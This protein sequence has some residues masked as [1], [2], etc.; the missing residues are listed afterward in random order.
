MCMAYPILNGSLQLHE[1]QQRRDLFRFG[2]CHRLHVCKF[3]LR[4]CGETTKLL[5]C[6]GLVVTQSNV[7]D[8]MFGV[9]AENKSRAVL[10]DAVGAL[11]CLGAI[12]HTLHGTELS[13]EFWESTACVR[14]STAEV[15]LVRPSTSISLSSQGEEQPIYA[16]KF[17]KECRSDSDLSCEVKNLMRAQ[18]HPNIC[19]FEGIFHSR[20]C[21]GVHQCLMLMEAYPRGDLMSIM[22]QHG[23][24][25]EIEALEATDGVLQA[26]SHIH[27]LG[28]IHRDV[29]PQNVVLTASGISVLV[30]FGL[31]FHVI[32]Q[33][34]RKRTCGSPCSIAP[35]IAMGLGCVKRSD[36]FG[37]GTVMYSVLG[38][39]LPF[40]GE[41]RN[42]TIQACKEARVTFPSNLFAGVTKGSQNLAKMMLQ[43][44]YSS[45]PTA[46]DALQRLDSC[47]AMVHAKMSNLVDETFIE[48]TTLAT[49][50]RQA[51][52]T[53]TELV[54]PVE[55]SQ[56][57]V[58]HESTHCMDASAKSEYKQLKVSEATNVSTTVDVTQDALVHFA[59]PV[60]DDG[61]DGAPSTHGISDELSN[62]TGSLRSIRKAMTWAPQYLAK[63][64]V[65]SCKS[66][67][68][69]VSDIT[70]FSK[71]PHHRVPSRIRQSTRSASRL[72]S[73]ITRGSAQTRPSGR[74]NWVDEQLFNKVC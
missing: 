67:V 22:Q 36:I 31:S 66:S 1:C 19:R 70:T 43:R 39:Q 6:V 54:V 23:A 25:V 48:E 71:E 13:H 60:I 37:C 30:D 15:S 52:Y 50:P 41:D 55:M 65:D 12:C 58:A 38:G 4:S 61:C 24:L 33:S 28:I 56:L 16:A 51:Q 42:S 69:S 29:K 27:K 8:C 10:D 26:L 68:E 47:K 9:D 35:E 32:D 21:T 34:D 62:G 59:S 17:W 2:G 14:G 74:C 11:R 72:F 3:F 57:H 44:T 20:T 40:F 53:N 49:L 18:G 63:R 5:R 46:D 64:V 7:N 45:R 73:R